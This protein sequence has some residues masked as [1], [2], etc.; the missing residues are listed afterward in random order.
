LGWKTV[1]TIKLFELD[2]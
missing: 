1:A 2:I